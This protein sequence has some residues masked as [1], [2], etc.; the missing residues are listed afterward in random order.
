MEKFIYK[1]YLKDKG[2]CDRLIDYHKLN[3]EYKF[4]G[5]VGK[6]VD[7]EAKDSIDVTFF[8]SSS[9]PDIQNYFKE[10]QVGIDN[11]YSKYKL[12]G[13]IR[14]SNG[15]NIQYYPPGGGFKVWHWER[16]SAHNYRGEI[17]YDRCLVFMTY[18]NDV[19]DGGETEWYYQKIKIKPKK[20][21]TVI[22]PS[23]FT[24]LHRGVVSPTQE[25]Y[26]VTGWFVFTHK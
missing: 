12:L 2:L 1:Y 13:N 7:K 19:T 15:S 20:G 11:Y 25:K 5:V 22:W 9:H 23:D 4:S 24:H 6:G 18:L 17:N 21:L 26:I 14:T 3:T 8:N 10:L 16:D